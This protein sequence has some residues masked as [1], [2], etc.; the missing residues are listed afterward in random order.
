M[1]TTVSRRDFLG[2]AFATAALA[3]CRCPLCGPRWSA[4]V[5]VQLYSIE[6]YIK[7]V[8]ISQTLKEVAAIGYAGVEVA[9]YDAEKREFYG[10]KA[11]ELKRMLDDNGLEFCGL[12]TSRSRLEPDVISRICEYA[13]TC[14]STTVICPGSGNMPEGL[15]WGNHHKCHGMKIPGIADHAKMLCDFYNRAAEDAAKLGCRVGIHNHQWEFLIKLPDGR[16]FWDAFF[17]G[18]SEKV[19]M[20]Q[21]VGWTTA[22]G[23]DPCEQ[24]LKYPHRSPTLHAK[25]NGYGCAG[26]FDAILGIPGKNADGTSVKRVEWERLFPVAES[27]GVEWYVVECEKHG[28]D[29]SAITGSYEFLRQNGFGR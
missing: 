2:G 11:P 17:S 12:H 21:D 8:G 20:E 22:A 24:Y 23:Y 27:D 26:A 25:E 15:N 6:A 1:N 5:A 28:N 3:G 18:T 10:A 9:G 14:G 29:L 13:R 4:K 7:R 19:L 16:T